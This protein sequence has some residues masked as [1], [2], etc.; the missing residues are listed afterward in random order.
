MT[1]SANALFH[2]SEIITK[3]YFNGMVDFSKHQR[4]SPEEMCNGGSVRGARCRAFPKLLF[5]ELSRNSRLGNALHL[6]PLT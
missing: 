1:V 6:T 3:P 4:A 5:R 2:T